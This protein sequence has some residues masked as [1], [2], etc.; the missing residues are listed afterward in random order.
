MFGPLVAAFASRILAA[1]AHPPPAPNATA[2]FLVFAVA[3]SLQVFTEQYGTEPV[4][5]AF[6]GDALFALVTLSSFSLGF[7][8]P[9]LHYARGT[10]ER[11][12]VQVPVGDVLRQKRVLW[13]VR[14]YALAA[15]TACLA[16]QFFDVRAL[17]M[18]MAAHTRDAHTWSSVIFETE[19][20]LLHLLTEFAVVQEHLALMAADQ[21]IAF[22]E[23]LHVYATFLRTLS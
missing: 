8:R 5:R 17:V 4:W 23:C 10:L 2:S 9:R 21:R 1:V 3:T 18:A 6:H 19:P 15:A 22:E 20:I 13:P 16:V 12:L 7:R 14:W 11:R